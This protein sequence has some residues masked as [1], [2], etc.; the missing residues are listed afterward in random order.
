MRRVRKI[1]TSIIWFF[2]GLYLLLLILLQIPAIQD[3]AGAKVANIISQELGTKVEIKRIDIGLFNRIIIDGITIYDQKD[4]L[5]LQGARLSAKIE[6]MPL[7]EGKV[8]IAS[9]QIFGTHVNL[10]Q[11]VADKPH[12]FQFVIDALSSKE[13]SS[14]S[15][16]NL[17]INSLIIRHGSVTYN[18]NYM[19]KKEGVLDPAH[20]KITEISAHLLLKTVAKDSINLNVKKIS[21][22]EQSGLKIN[23][24]SLRFEGG[25]SSCSLKDFEIV[26]PQSFFRIDSI[27]ANYDIDKTASN[28]PIVFSGAIGK[29][30]IHSHDLAFIQPEF[31][32]KQCTIEMASVF[33]GTEKSL[34][35]RN[36]D[37]DTDGD[38]IA[39]SIGKDIKSI[40]RLGGVRISASGYVDKTMCANTNCNI[41][42]DAGSIKLIAQT[43]TAQ[44]ISG[45][46]QS[47][48]IRIGQILADDKFGSVILNADISGNTGLTHT[49]LSLKLSSRIQH[50]EFK[51]HNYNNILFGL[52]HTPSATKGE[53]ELDD[54]YTKFKV[55]G[56]LAKGRNGSSFQ[57]NAIIDKL[58][59]KAINISDKWGDADFR[60]N[61]YADIKGTNIANAQGV[62]QIR[63]FAYSTPDRQIELSKLVLDSHFENKEQVITLNSDFANIRINGQFDIKSLSNSALNQLV[64]KIPAIPGLTSGKSQAKN[65]IQFYGEIKNSDLIE[66]IG[67][68]PLHVV[69][70]ITVVGKINDQNGEMYANCSAPHF[71]YNNTELKNG[72]IA[73]TA[74]DDTLNYDFGA[75]KMNGNNSTLKLNI[76]GKAYDNRLTASL[77]FDNNGTK[78]MEGLL[79]TETVFYNS[80]G[81]RKAD[82]SITPS[83]LNINDED[84]TINPANITYIQDKLSINNFKISNNNQSITINGIASRYAED[85]LTVN[86]HRIN[87]ENIL[88]L[89]NF[90]S[91]RF[92]GLAS[93]KASIKAPFGDMEA[94]AKIL[95]DKFT[96]EGGRMGVLDANASWDKENKQIKIDAVA[97]DGPDA[98]TYVNGYISPSPGYIDL[99]IR[100]EGTHLD[101][102][103]SF[104]KSFTSDVNGHVRGFVK[105]LGPLKTVNLVGNLIVNGE[106]DIKP[107]NCKYFLKNDTVVC[108]PDEIEIIPSRIED[109][110]GNKGVLNGFIRHK[111]LTKLTYDLFVEADNLLVYDFKDFGNEVFYGTVFGTGNA[112]IHGRSRELRMNVDMTTQKNSTF[113]YNVSTPDAIVDQKFITWNNKTNNPANNEDAEAKTPMK[114]TNLPGDTYINFKINATT[115][116]TVKFLMDS[117]TN[118][119]ISLHGNGMLNASYYNKGGFNMFGTYT[120]EDGTYSMT[121]Q[122][123]IKKDFT[124]K[125]GGTLVFGGNPENA[126]LNLQAVHTVNGVSLSDLNVGNS[127][128]DNTTRVN[129]LLDIT[130]KPFDLQLDFGLELPN[131]SNDQERNIQSVIQGEDGMKQQVIYL[132][133]FGRFMPQTN[134]NETAQDNRK[135]S[136]TSQAMQGL[137]SGTL[138]TQ[139]NNVLKSAIN[140]N[141]WNFGANIS[142][143][144]EG[145]NNAEYEGLLNGRLL[146]N[147]LLINGQFGYRDNA[148]TANSSFIGDFDLRY[149]LLPNGNIALK[150]YNQTNDRY[151]TKSSL[152]TQ[153]IGFIIKKDFTNLGDLF[154]R[155]KGKK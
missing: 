61:I 54:P 48:S 40:S 113:V 30:K 150:V 24:L 91:V 125:Q 127:Y 155:K 68:I 9:A 90:R 93:G 27:N 15:Q 14:D 28:I 39:A 118:D 141:N 63:D 81:Q 22:N 108:R 139:I 106:M 21:L 59:L 3:F 99:G 74:P 109:I 110:Y 115:D 143:G 152:N 44:N 92:S 41:A 62:I 154:G 78:Y 5:L 76:F 33:N 88:D 75:I 65:R 49:P 134:N 12:N 60:G 105:L 122:D 117:N 124:F 83:F 35:I 104:T 153:G 131:A 64:S 126:N 114:E 4:E 97:D 10:Y 73:I 53:I 148:A 146:N 72:H 18:R 123:I 82:I 6:L 19:P 46:L 135:M 128:S 45:T 38:F 132:L 138:S 70:P 42:T 26:M 23:K 55:S 120:V 58:N 147:R 11:D 67:G 32:K 47:D 103:E 36:L 145:W 7:T 8:S 133:G 130:G 86:L 57:A 98:M 20:L 2:I 77:Y 142:T 149:L 119:Y 96:F 121:I 140:S 107:L 94:N 1:L 51:N 116:A 100:A 101:F 89:V 13:S 111:H 95:V 50:F 112:S 144:D 31:R 69:K 80:E 17:R 84:W 71:I 151:F 37:I 56:E 137:L 25:K 85:V 87:V 136:Q 16:L 43:D 79:N 29:S 66:A 34:S 52:T 102:M 129:C